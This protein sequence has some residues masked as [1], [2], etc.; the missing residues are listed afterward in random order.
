MKLIFEHS[1]TGRRGFT[2]PPSD[3]P[4]RKAQDAIPAEL[5]RKDELELPEVGELDIVRHY[6]NLSR[7][8][9]GVDT[10]FYPLGSCTM[11]YSPK[12][13]ETAAANPR[14]TNLHPYQPDDLAQGMLEML[15]NTQE[16][17]KEISGMS[18]VS[19]QPAA[20]AHG[21]LTS[22]LV[23]KA[24][25]DDKRPG[26]MKVLIP[27]SA[28]GTNPSS[29]IFAGFETV[30]VK[31]NERGLVDL[32][33][34]EKNVDEK[35]AALML[36]NPNTLG[37]FD[38]Q[39]QKIAEI[40]HEKGALLYLDGANLNAIMGIARPA[41]F[42]V[43]AMHFN[44]HKSFSTPHG[45]GGPGS[46]PV[47]V[48]KELAPYLPV[49][50]VAKKGDKFCLDYSIP[51]SIGRCR[52]FYGNV[53]VIVRAY[54]Y[55][56]MLGKE[57]IP[58]VAHHAVINA[59][60]LA[61]RLKKYFLLPYDRLCMHECVFSGNWQKKY[62]VKTLDIAK[63]LL[64]LGFHP[65]TVYFPLIVPEA[66]MIEPTENESKETLDAFADAMIQI[67][68]EAQE[69]PQLVTSAPQTTPVKRLDEVKAAKEPYVRWRP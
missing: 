40:L 22:L 1:R 47:G 11:K 48:V 62:G 52:S 6:T 12:V 31:S 68:K 69:N 17:L 42:G 32:E 35:T 2:L 30:Q 61:A 9:V 20:G 41:D 23:M 44:L 60:Y 53:G 64:D 59:N 3:V 38:D 5:L 19:L 57:G 36:T 16:Y 67:A 4:E 45:G 25:L 56:R 37:L 33:D 51:K 39:V 46:G 29:S 18:A 54:V 50:V 28:H 7:R 15:Y 34:L 24:F 14:F 8:N 10:V 58:R 55:L 43:D 49:P 63:R 27:D 13:N 65:P 66:I 21:E 26:R